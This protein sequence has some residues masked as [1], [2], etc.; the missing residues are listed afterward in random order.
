MLLNE[1][2]SPAFAISKNGK[3]TVFLPELIGEPEHPEISYLF[4]HSLFF[5]RA[6][7]TGCPITGVP[8]DVVQ[9]L[10]NTDKMLII[11]IDLDKVSDLNSGRLADPSKV[12]RRYYEATINRDS[13]AE[14]SVDAI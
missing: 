2:Y 13:F 4:E 8:E 9:Q 3:V 7:D 12:F 5:K 6:A 10:R 1:I 14:K 11:E